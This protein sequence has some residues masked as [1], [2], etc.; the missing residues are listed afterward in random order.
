MLSEPIGG[1]LKAARKQ[2]NVSREELARRVGVST[3]LVAELERGQRPAPADVDRSSD[4]PSRRG[5]GPAIRPVEIGS[6]LVPRAGVETGL[7]DRVGRHGGFRGASR[8]HRRERA[9]GAGDGDAVWNA[10]AFGSIS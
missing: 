10:S 4:T 6:T 8:D 2:L 7:P 5:R 3:R 1:L 9:H